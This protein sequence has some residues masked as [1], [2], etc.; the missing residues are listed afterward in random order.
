MRLPALNL[1]IFSGPPI[2]EPPT[3]IDPV[4]SFLPRTRSTTE[5]GGQQQKTLPVK[6]RAEKSGGGAL[7][8]SMVDPE[9]D[10]AGLP[11]HHSQKRRCGA[12]TWGTS[13][14]STPQ[15]R[16]ADAGVRRRIRLLVYHFSRRPLPAPAPF[17]WRGLR[18]PEAAPRSDRKSPSWERSARK[19][20]SCPRS[21]R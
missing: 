21:P 6:S 7:F 13:Q 5:L 8:A 15:R 12:E 4:T 20:P 9:N 3:G 1:T 19:P 10:V 14:E 18:S 17:C 11:Q 2:R 16:F